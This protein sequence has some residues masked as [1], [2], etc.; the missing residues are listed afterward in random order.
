MA[1]VAGWDRHHIYPYDCV[2]PKG[3]LQCQRRRDY[4]P[5]FTVALELWLARRK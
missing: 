2:S 4:D 1:K 5:R 3:Q